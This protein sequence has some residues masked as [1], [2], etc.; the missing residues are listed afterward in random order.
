MLDFDTSDVTHLT[1]TLTMITF[2][3]V[4][5]QVFSRWVAVEKNTKHYKF[6]MTLQTY[7]YAYNFLTGKKN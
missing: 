2:S 7:D 5:H 6:C 1:L 3:H 4:V